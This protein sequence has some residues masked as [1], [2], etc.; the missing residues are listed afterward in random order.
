M[1][2][3]EPPTARRTGAQTRAEAQRVALALF[4][5][6]GYEATSMQQ[7]ADALGIR[8][9]S[10][11]YHFAGKDEIVRSLLEGRA[12]EA[13]ALA[14]WVRE[15][16]P[17]PTLA[18]DAVLRWVGSSS[19]EKLRGIR[20]MNANPLLVG[21]IARQ[22]GVDV[23]DELASMLDALVPSDTDPRARLLVRMAFMSLATAVA[24]AGPD[25]SDE[26]VVATARA[27][28]EAL[29]AAAGSLVRTD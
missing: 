25:T 9:A 26:E 24:A 23:G 1:A 15:Q 8:K 28:A 20:V 16:P 7:I 14:R 3:D 6:Q 13:R 11:Y 12:D 2:P 29:V 21:A 4:S 17:S 10:L 19:A 5:N 18:R 27:A 22:A